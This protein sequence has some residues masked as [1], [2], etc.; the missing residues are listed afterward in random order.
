ME[1]EVLSSLERFVVV[2]VVIVLGVVAVSEKQMCV[3]LGDLGSSAVQV[4]C[5]IRSGSVV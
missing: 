4:M 5:V 2:V 3:C 1:G